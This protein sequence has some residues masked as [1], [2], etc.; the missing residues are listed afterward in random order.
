MKEY[1]V[2]VD[3][4]GY[5][6][7]AK[8][9]VKKTG[10]KYEDTARELYILDPIKETLRKLQRQFKN[11]TFHDSTDDAYLFLEKFSHVFITMLS[12]SS[13]FIG[14]E[15]LRISSVI[16][17]MACE[18]HGP[19]CINEIHNYTGVSKSHIYPKTREFQ[20]ILNKL[21]KPGKAELDN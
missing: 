13:N 9:I 16:V 1:L 20:D 11:A 10:H 18:L 19:N 5:E 4:L 14:L 17:N 7:L 8:Q 2:Y 15:P 3:I 21:V 12:K 6:E